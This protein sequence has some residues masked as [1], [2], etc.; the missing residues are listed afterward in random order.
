MIAVM[1]FAVFDSVAVHA[2]GVGVDVPYQFFLMLP[3]VASILLLVMI[4]SRLGQ[5]AKLGVPYLRH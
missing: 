3:Y 1:V 5:P 4:R 2:Q